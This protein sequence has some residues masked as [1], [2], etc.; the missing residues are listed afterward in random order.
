MHGLARKSLFLSKL[1][2]V[3]LPR[4]TSKIVPKIWG[5]ETWL[6]NNSQYCGKLLHLTPG[7]QCS[8]HYHPIKKETFHILAGAVRLEVYKN[9]VPLN[10]QDR[11]E[12]ILQEGQTYHLLPKTPHRFS[13]AS[14][15][16]ATILEISTP[17][18]DADVVR[19]EDSRKL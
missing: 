10:P 12:L 3:K 16:G 18:S 8:L 17:H 9:G 13:A 6:V 15:E 5:S 2:E 1:K 14:L 11:V 19:I 4:L 7:Y